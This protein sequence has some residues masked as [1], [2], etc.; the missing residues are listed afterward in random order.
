MKKNT[1]LWLILAIVIVWMWYSQAKPTIVPAIPK[2]G[3][4]A[5]PAP[6]PTLTPAG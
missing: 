4:A 6:T 1:V 5:K 3:T 2:P